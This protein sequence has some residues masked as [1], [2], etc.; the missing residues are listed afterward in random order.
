MLLGDRELVA[1]AR[2]IYAD[3]QR[4]PRHAN[5]HDDL[6]RDWGIVC[7]E[8]N[9]RG[10]TDTITTAHADTLDSPDTRPC[11]STSE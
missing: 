7:Q 4:T 1:E 8:L 11:V 10:I 6:M 3:I 9:F 2:R 5:G